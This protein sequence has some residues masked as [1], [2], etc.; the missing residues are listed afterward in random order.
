M[1]LSDVYD[2]DSAVAYA[3]QAYEARRLSPDLMQ[4]LA[5]S[6]PDPRELDRRLDAAGIDI[7]VDFSQPGLGPIPSEGVIAAFERHGFRWGGDYPIPDN[8]HFELVG[9]TAAQP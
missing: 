6:V 9:G 8:H 5:H 4:T 7:N 2:L 3:R 1:T